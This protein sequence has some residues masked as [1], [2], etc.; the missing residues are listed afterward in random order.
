MTAIVELKG[1]LGNQLF[2]LAFAKWLSQ[3]T[4]DRV[5][6]DVDWFRR[7]TARDTPRELALDVHNLG[8]PVLEAHWSHRTL[9][10]LSRRPVLLPYS[11]TN[12]AKQHSIWPFRRHSGYYQDYRFAR[13]SRQFL[14][15]IFI[16]HIG[17]LPKQSNS[18]TLHCR[19]GDYVSK[20]SARMFHG[21][22]DP[23]WSFK[24]ARELQEK[25]EL[26]SIKLYTDSPEMLLTRYAEQIQDFQVC[27]P[28]SAWE[29]LGEMLCGRAFVLSN[30]S[31]SWWAATAS[32]WFLGPPDEVIFPTPWFAEPSVADSELFNPEWSAIERDILEKVE[33][34]G[35]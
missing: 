15:Q 34:D 2:Q 30:S 27:L 35:A 23:L 5:V 32:S 21:V 28:S 11:E 24:R 3:R 6:I 1:G 4:S 33:F 26:D 16:S 18:V 31:F 29:T 25:Y 19:L 17:A 12:A 14:E 9:R 22:T 20:P 10:A 13:D 8:L 7:E